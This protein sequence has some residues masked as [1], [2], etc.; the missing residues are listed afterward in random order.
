MGAR[1]LSVMDCLDALC[2]ERQYRRALPM[3]EALQQVAALAGT[4]FD[5]KV[6]AALEQNW[7]RLRDLAAPG[8]RTPM[9]EMT[10]MTE[11]C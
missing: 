4:Q 7:P 2:S 10:A 3:S 5:P 11:Q 9:R 6:V 1:I 8:N